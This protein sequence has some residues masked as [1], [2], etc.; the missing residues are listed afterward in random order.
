MSLDQIAARFTARG[1]WRE[2]LEPVLAM[3]VVLGK[4]QQE[5]EGR[6]ILYRGPG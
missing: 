2:R 5:D 4:A 3:L 1:R 6:A